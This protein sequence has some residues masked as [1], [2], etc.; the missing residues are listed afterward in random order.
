MYIQFRYLLFMIS[1]YK[2]KYMQKD[3]AYTYGTSV[4]KN[5]GFF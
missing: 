3:F 2:F 4:K 5:Y 1:N